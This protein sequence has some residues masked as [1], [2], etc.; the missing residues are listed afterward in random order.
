MMRVIDINSGID[1]GSAKFPAL[2]MARMVTSRKPIP[3]GVSGISP[4]ILPMIIAVERVSHDVILMPSPIPEYDHHYGSD[5]TR[6]L[7]NYVYHIE[8]DR[9]VQDLFERLGNL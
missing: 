2:K 9:L 7:I 3:P 8:R 1:D 5:P 4:A 6:H